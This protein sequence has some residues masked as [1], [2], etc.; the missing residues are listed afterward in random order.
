MNQIQEKLQNISE[1]LDRIQKEIENGNFT[2]EE[3]D[4]MM[5]NYAKPLHENIERLVSLYKDLNSD[6][7]SK[8]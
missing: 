6:Q 8:N 5:E 2:Q 4:M 7:P 3:I 1:R